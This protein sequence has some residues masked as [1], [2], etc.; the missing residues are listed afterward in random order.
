[1]SHL[2]TLPPALMS[3]NK[4]SFII[5]PICGIVL[6]TEYGLTSTKCTWDPG[7]EKELLVRTKELSVK[8]GYYLITDCNK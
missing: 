2:G 3:Q 6:A 5:Y 1:M 4:S 8:Y 7:A